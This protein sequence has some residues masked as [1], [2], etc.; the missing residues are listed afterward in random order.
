MN[1]P[2]FLLQT[3]SKPAPNQDWNASLLWTILSIVRWISA[4]GMSDMLVILLLIL[5]EAGAG[6]PSG[7]ELSLIGSMGQ[8]ASVIL[9]Q[10]SSS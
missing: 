3:I 7:P 4:V 8:A 1:G 2:Y 9:K 5:R 6:F 10:G